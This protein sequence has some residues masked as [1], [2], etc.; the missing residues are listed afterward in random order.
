MK[1]ISY[2][3]SECGVSKFCPNP[4]S[5][6]LTVDAAKRAVSGWLP[7]STSGAI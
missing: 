3:I 7:N 1:S 5:E 4:L 6:L 2:W